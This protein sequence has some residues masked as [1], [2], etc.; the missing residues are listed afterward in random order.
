MTAIEEYTQLIRFRIQNPLPITVHGENHHVVPKC[1]GG[2]TLPDNEIRL[3][4]A[5]HAKAHQLLPLIYTEGE[6][7]TGLSCAANFLLTS[8]DGVKLTPEEAGE[9]RERFAKIQSERMR[10]R[11]PWNK[12]VTGVYHHTEEWKRQNSL[13]HRGRKRSEETK[14]K[15]GEAL[16]GKPKS[17]EARKHMSE[18]HAD[19]S[20]RKD[21]TTG[22]FAKRE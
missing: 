3:T 4:S 20:K 22:R 17:A 21:P 12:G 14:R 10:G 5:E 2:S 11:T 19:V 8:R 16:R 6:E 1:C 9:I 18:N 7:F 13:R 15:I